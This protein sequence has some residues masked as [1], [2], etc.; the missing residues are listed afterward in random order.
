MRAKRLKFLGGAVKGIFS[1]NSKSAQVLAPREVE[2][3][4]QT[5]RT[6]CSRT[7][8]SANKFAARTM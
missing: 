2:G 7:Y 4:Q 8:S 1:Q 6:T 5:Q 3:S